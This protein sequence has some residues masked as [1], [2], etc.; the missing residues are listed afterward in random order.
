MK[1]IYHVFDKDFNLSSETVFENFSNSDK[2]RELFPELYVS[3]KKKSKSS[4]V[5]TKWNKTSAHH[6]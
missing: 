1:K 5:K 2:I 4:N 6:Y 3:T